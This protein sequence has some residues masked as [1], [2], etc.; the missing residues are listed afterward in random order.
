MNNR[1]SPTLW[2]TARVIANRNR[3]AMFRALLLS[4]GKTVE[5]VASE[6]GLSMATASL[7]LKALQARGLVQATRISR[8]V[9]YRAVPDPSAEITPKVFSLLCNAFK[10]WVLSDDDVFRAFTAYTHPR[11]IAII[12]F[13]SATSQAVTTREIAAGTGMSTDAA[14]RHLGKLTRRGILAHENGGWRISGTPPNPLAES[15]RCLVAE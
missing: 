6:T 11:R 7:Y 1:L 10:V 8:F 3:I 13:L 14:W 5:E 2:R 9:S 12:R 4:S 15:L